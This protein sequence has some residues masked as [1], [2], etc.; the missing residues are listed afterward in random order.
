MGEKVASTVSSSEIQT[1]EVRAKR[2]KQPEVFWAGSIQAAH[3][4]AMKRCEQPIRWRRT[5]TRV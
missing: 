2:F 4:R 5:T 3:H 1:E